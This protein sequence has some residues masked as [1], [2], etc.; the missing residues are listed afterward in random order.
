[1][2]RDFLYEIPATEEQR[3]ELRMYGDEDADHPDLTYGDAEEYLADHREAL[4]EDLGY[5]HFAHFYDEDD[6]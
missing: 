2:D 6:D 4:L 3:R 1:M 5:I